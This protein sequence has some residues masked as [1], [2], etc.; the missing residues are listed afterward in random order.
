MAGLQ[1][2]RGS[3]G[4]GCAIDVPQ[5]FKLARQFVQKVSMGPGHGSRCEMR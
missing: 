4:S 3:I 5:S 1:M 2:S